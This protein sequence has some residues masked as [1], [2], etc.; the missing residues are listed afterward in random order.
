MK[1]LFRRHQKKINKLVRLINKS[2]EEDEAFRGRIY[3]RQYSGGFIEFSDGSGGLW[4][5]VIRVYDKIT[6]TY[7]TIIGDEYDMHRI[8][9]NEVNTF[10]TDDLKYDIRK[11]LA[12]AIDYRSMPHDPRNA[13]PF[14]PHYDK[15][16]SYKYHVW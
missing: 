15:N 1:K 12:L 14:Y 16:Y 8:L 6:N 10:I 5:G 9:I 7:K 3:L 2:L 13:D 11:S 4:Y